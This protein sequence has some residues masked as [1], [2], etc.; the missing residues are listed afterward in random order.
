M[1][2]GDVRFPIQSKLTVARLLVHPAESGR[3]AGP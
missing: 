3:Q 1:S 2:G